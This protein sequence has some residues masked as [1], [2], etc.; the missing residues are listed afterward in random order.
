[1]NETIV[2]IEKLGV[3]VAVVYLCTGRFVGVHL[4]ECV[5]ETL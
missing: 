1:M 2:G 5:A 3:Y 4:F